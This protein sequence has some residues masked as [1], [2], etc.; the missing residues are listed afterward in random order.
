MNL[1]AR[2]GWWVARI[3]LAGLAAWTAYVWTS[4]GGWGWAIAFL[5]ALFVGVPIVRRLENVGSR[6]HT[7]R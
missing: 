4:G 6:E 2:V 5:L 3:A 7:Q 1:M